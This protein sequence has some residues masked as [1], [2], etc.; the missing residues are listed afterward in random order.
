MARAPRLV[1]NNGNL[2]NPSQYIIG[3]DHYTKT[4]HETG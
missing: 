4:S 3:R 1:D 2:I